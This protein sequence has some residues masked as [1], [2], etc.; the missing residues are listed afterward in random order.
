ML[1]QQGHPAEGLAAR[2][3]RVLLDV[4]V[5][6]QMR[7]EVAAIGERAI[8]VLTAERFLAGVSPDVTLEEPRPGEGLAAEMALAR[9]GVGPDVH[10]QR[11]H[12]DVD[13]LA[14]LAGERFLGLSF[15]GGAVELLVLRE[16]G[17]R[18]V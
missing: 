7:P 11:S 10:L 14:V 2:R 18:R 8:A 9:Q 5:G 15:G 12:A 6:L 17:V 4:A 3:A 1:R 13:L 16:S